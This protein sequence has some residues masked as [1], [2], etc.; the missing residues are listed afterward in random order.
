MIPTVTS[1]IGFFIAVAGFYKDVF[2]VEVGEL[3]ADD[4]DD[5]WFLRNWY[6]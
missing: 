1:M 5:F 3:S 4:E 6:L 2:P